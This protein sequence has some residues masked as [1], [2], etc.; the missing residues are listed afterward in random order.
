M[1]YILTDENG[2]I[3]GPFTTCEQQDDGYL[4]DGSIYPLNVTGPVVKSEVPDDFL[5][6]ATIV[7]FNKNQSKLRAETYPVES[8]PIFFQWQ[9]GSKTEQEWLDAVEKVKAQY[10]YK[11]T[12]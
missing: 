6:P 5:S 1:K 12:V 9:R 4:A 11:E 8:D 3:L 10:P 7:L 2:G